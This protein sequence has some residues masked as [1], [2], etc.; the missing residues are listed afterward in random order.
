MIDSMFIRVSRHDQIVCATGIAGR[1]ETQ[2]ARRIGTEHIALEYAV[3]DNVSICCRNPF[4]IVWRTG[5][6]LWN[7]RS[8]Q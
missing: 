4:G 6:C 3:N 7:V 1:L 2:P 8:L 5:H